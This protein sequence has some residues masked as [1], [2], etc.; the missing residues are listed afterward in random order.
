VL[1]PSQDLRQKLGVIGVAAAAPGDVA[2]TEVD[3][4]IGSTLEGVSPS[5]VGGGTEEL[6]AVALI[7][8]LIAPVAAG[9]ALLAKG[10]P[11]A[12]AETAQK[13]E[14]RISNVLRDEATHLSLRDELFAA[15]GNKTTQTTV[16][17]P[18]ILSVP[19]AGH[20]D[21]RCTPPK[22]VDT[23]LEVSLTRI[24]LAGRDDLRSQKVMF[25]EGRVRLVRCPD[26]Q[27]IYARSFLHVAGRHL[28][29][30]WGE[31]DARLFN[32]AL[33]DSYAALAETITEELFLLWRNPTN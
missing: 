29:R 17:L 8:V 10:D 14:D 30:E 13:L 5:I 15:I 18:A 31:N 25:V 3:E 27:E 2:D 20:L 33:N 19:V 23:V 26:S 28:I 32:R 12:T 6:A 7:A 22:D 11:D 21:D 24:G 16:L 9:A 4:V 1:P